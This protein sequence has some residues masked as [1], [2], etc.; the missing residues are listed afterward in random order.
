[1]E[2]FITYQR[3]IAFPDTAE[4]TPAD[5][6][7]ASFRRFLDFLAAN[8]IR[9][10]FIRGNEPTLHE[11]LGEMLTLARQQQLVP[12]LETGGVLNDAGR[13]IL[14]KYPVPILWNLYHPSLYTA[15]Q[16]R[17]SL[18]DCRRLIAATS[19]RVRICGVIHDVRLDY[20]KM[21]EAI[22]SVSA[23]EVIFRVLHP[24]DLTSLQEQLPRFAASAI[25]FGNRGT[26][27]GLDCGLPPC[28]FTDEVLGALCRRGIELQRC[29][30]VPGVLPDLRVYHCRELL[31]DASASLNQFRNLS[32]LM[33]YLFERYR[34]LQ[35]DMGFLADCRDCVSLRLKR[36][37]G[38]CM[39]VKRAAAVAEIRRL[40]ESLAITAD[41]A[42]LLRLGQL[43]L[44]VQA[45]PEAVTCLS[46]VRRLEPA[47]GP[48]HLFLARAF[49]RQGDTAA[50]AEEYVKASRLLPEE[51]AIHGEAADFLQRTGMPGLGV[52]PVGQ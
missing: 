31:G 46:E 21:L 50:A 11:G 40:Q 8:Q 33:R 37:L 35:Y 38:P 4:G 16:W 13:T 26:P 44:D 42:K 43:Y 2:A 23:R 15:A 51:R 32:E 7:L 27:V 5:M 17:T 36:C 14:E 39:A 30:P 25:E 45:I 29:T 49:R 34:D 48:A 52:P 9:S 3:A 12:L 24:A 47:N 10:C 28:G 1:M 18:D 41:T 6:P 22:R 20:A 19:G